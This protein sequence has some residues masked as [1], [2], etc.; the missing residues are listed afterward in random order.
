[1]STQTAVIFP[2]ARGTI[3]TSSIG[4]TLPVIGEVVLIDIFSAKAVLTLTTDSSSVS[5]EAIED[6]TL[7]ITRPI[8]NIA[9]IIV[10][11]LFVFFFFVFC[12]NTSIVVLSVVSLKVDVSLFF[13]KTF[14][15]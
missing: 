3:L 2:V 8:I 9:A 6:T 5:G 13:F 12:S 1:M 7:K 14:T 4:S 10:I 11:I 15:P